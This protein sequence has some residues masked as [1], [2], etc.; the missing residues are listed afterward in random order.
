MTWL[1]WE[2]D[3]MWAERMERR[4]PDFFVREPEPGPLP[5]D[6]G[7]EPRDPEEPVAGDF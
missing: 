6:H 1:D 2:D 4:D 3:E 5:V 7:P